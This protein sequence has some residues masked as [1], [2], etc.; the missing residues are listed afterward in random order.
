VLAEVLGV[1]RP[2][3]TTSLQ[4]LEGRHLIRSTRR[5]IVVLDPAGL[6]GLARH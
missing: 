1:R 4:T 6:A 5:S 3:I 2:S